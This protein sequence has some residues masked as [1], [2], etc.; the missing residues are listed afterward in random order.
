MLFLHNSHTQ[1][2]LVTCENIPFIYGFSALVELG[3]NT[4]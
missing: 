1:L 2:L 3:K 4:L